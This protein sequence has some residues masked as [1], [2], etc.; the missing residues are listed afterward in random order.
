MTC[1]CMCE[2]YAQDNMIDGG[3][4]VTLLYHTPLSPSYYINILICVLTR[5]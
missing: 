3:Y 4:F 5:D 1:T 2:V